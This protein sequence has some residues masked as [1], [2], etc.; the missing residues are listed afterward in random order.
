MA[1]ATGSAT[2]GTAPVNPKKSQNRTELAKDFAK[3]GD[4]TA[5]LREAEQAIALSAENAEA[6][7]VRGIC[8]LL[9]AVNNYRLLEI[10]SCLTGVDAEGLRLEMDEH[11]KA[12]TKSFQR[13]T[14]IDSEYSEAYANQATAQERLENYADA[15]ALNE[16]ALEIPHRLLNLGLTRANLGWAMFRAGDDVG[17]AKE[18]RQ[19][20]QF[21]DKLC[22][23]KYRLGRV[24]FKRE[25]WN[26]AIEQFRAV[27]DTP[28][29]PIQEAHLYFIRTMTKISMN[30]TT[31]DEATS[32]TA[33]GSAIA[34]CVKLAPQSCIAAQ[35]RAGL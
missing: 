28:D 31:Q 25:E 20:L 21:N 12:A 11:L 8:R 6:Y 24:Y 19:A 4:V 34:A 32:S 10:D 13:A 35:C 9:Q 2:C 33:L 17:A 3:R 22:V 1:A 29:C 7:E 23:A 5:C 16:R 27:V 26:K 15:I 14:K 30:E 18:L